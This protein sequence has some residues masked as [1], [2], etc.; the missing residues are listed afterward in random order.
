[1]NGK[2]HSQKDLAFEKIVEAIGGTTEEITESF[3]GKT[4]EQ[5]NQD[6]I[7]M[8]GTEGSDIELATLIETTVND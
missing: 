8:F 7:N 1:M 5:I 3:A 2:N 4:A 6:L